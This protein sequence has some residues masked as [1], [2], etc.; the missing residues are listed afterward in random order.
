[1][2][3]VKTL[4]LCNHQRTQFYLFITVG[5][6]PFR[7]KDFDNALG[8]ARVSFALKDDMDAITFLCKPRC[9]YYQSHSQRSEILQVLH[10]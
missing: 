9:L 2:R 1:M 8:V 4:F 5:N 6:K 10:K 3:M 7:S